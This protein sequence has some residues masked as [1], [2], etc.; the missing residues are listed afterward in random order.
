MVKK[1]YAEKLLD[2][3]WQKKRLEVFER[4]EFKCRLCSNTE[5]TLHV[6][7]NSYVGN[8]WDIDSS[9]LKTVC[10]Y[11]HAIIHHVIKTHKGKVLHIDRVSQLHEFEVYLIIEGQL[12]IGLYEKTTDNKNPVK[13]SVGFFKSGINRYNSILNSF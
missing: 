6:H 13:F 9:E 7:H 2:P 11:C 3:K 5:S 4:D 12:A 1:T 10:K 8:P